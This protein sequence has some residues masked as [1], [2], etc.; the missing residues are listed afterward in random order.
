[1]EVAIDG[2]GL[3]AAA[4]S[5]GPTS[6]SGP[7]VQEATAAGSLH[8]EVAGGAAEGQLGIGAAGM[9]AEL[10]DENGPNPSSAVSCNLENAAD[11]AFHIWQKKVIQLITL[12][13]L[14]L[15]EDTVKHL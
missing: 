1:M 9:S 4:V 14:T 15:K 3:L 11:R 8:S 2:T 10:L 5:S 12:S 7:A 13:L 6:A